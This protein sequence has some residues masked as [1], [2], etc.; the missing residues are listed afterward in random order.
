MHL[1]PHPLGKALIQ[2]GA[3]S[4]D[5][6]LKEVFADVGIALHNAVVADFMDA[7]RVDVRLRWLEQDLWALKPLPAD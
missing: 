2:S 3:T 1:R 5:D 7:F 4:H 6:V